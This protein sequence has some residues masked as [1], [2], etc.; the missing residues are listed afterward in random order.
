MLRHLQRKPHTVV[1]GTASL[2]PGQSVCF[3]DTFSQLN[4]ISVRHSSIWDPTPTRFLHGSPACWV[5]RYL[6]D[7]LC[8]E[9][10]PG[11]RVVACVSGSGVV[12]MTPTVGPD[13]LVQMQALL[14]MAGWCWEGEFTSLG[15]Q[16]PH[17]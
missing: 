11:H 14:S 17:V 1:R 10:G 9:K 12:L 4:H 5:S 3:P 2:V 13:S 7:G 6:G 15:A 8:T 16:L